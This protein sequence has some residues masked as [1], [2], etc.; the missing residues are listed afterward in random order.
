M[1]KY[2]LTGSY[3]TEGAKGLI[4]EGGSKRQ[5]AVTAALSSAGMTVEAFYFALGENDI[6]LIADGP[7][8]LTVTA[9]ALAVN[10]AGALKLSTTVLLTPAEV[11]AAVKK[12]IKYTP[13]KK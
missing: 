13:P 7:D 6:V 10:S 1:A 2:L 12:P 4:K 9:L 5:K 3:S 11:D 8:H